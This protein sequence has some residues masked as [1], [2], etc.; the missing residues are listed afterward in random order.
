MENYTDVAKK[1]KAKKIHVELVGNGSRVV[2]QMTE[3]NKKK[4][5]DR[6]DGYVRTRRTRSRDA[7]HGLLYV[8]AKTKLRNASQ[9]L[10]LL[11]VWL[12]DTRKRHIH[13]ERS[14]HRICGRDCKHSACAPVRQGRVDRAKP[15]RQ[16]LDQEGRV[17]MAE[18][19]RE[20]RGG[21]ERVREIG[22]KRERR[23]RGAEQGVSQ[24]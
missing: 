22:G 15:T 11:A 20:K 2:L 5:S 17:T 4:R 8:S 23:W 13:I 18:R 6:R 12:G 24:Q 9:V 14:F 10:E 21:A 7:T 1:G 3:I 16:N 19:E